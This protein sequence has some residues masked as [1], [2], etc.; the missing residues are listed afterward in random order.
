MESST[1]P[2]LRRSVFRVTAADDAVDQIL[3][4]L[5]GDQVEC[6]IDLR[7]VVNPG[8]TSTLAALR[9]GAE[10]REMY[11]AH[12]PE[13]VAERRFRHGQPSRALAWAARTSLRHRA[14][15]VI[16]GASSERE[17]SEEIADL[18]GL[19]VIELSAE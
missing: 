6:I 12:L 7:A 1:N 11:Y 2:R 15:L 16:R 5:V 4:L 13:V 17:A 19:R 8:A 14:C 18:A 10:S 9:L 3:K